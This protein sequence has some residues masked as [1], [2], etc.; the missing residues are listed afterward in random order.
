MR[1]APTFSI[2]A[3]DVGTGEVGVATASAI[4]AVGAVVPWVR[5]EV[6]AIATQSAAD[7]DHGL[8][9]LRLLARGQTPQTTVDQLIDGD[10]HR[11]WRQLAVLDAKGRAAAWTGPSCLNWAGHRVGYNFVCC[12]NEL[13]GPEVI[14]AMSLTFE[15]TN[16]RLP[17]RMLASLEAGQASGG[18]K[19]GKQSAAV[20]V[21]K[22]GG[23]KGGETDRYVDL[24]VDDHP[25]PLSEL[26]PLLA[27][28]REA[29]GRI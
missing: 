6:G 22:E 2:A 1:L 12:G 21:A 7:L 9:G 8:A 26:A 29:M 19:S 20:Y 17:E 23:F 27:L 3:L 4:L 25:D 10:I 28:L 14:E 13:A 15:T 11:D 24:R 5:A 18:Q 16:D